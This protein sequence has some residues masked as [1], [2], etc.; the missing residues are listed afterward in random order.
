MVLLSYSD[1][2]AKGIPY[3]TVHIWRLE[4][5]GEFPKRV[6]I[7]RARHGWLETEIDAWIADRVAA[8]DATE[9][10]A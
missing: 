1:L 9:V 2:R 6:P 4:K 8:R 3:S 5:A 10:A 7:G